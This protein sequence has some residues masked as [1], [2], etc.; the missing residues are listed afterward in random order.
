M[1]NQDTQKVEPEVKL[2]EEELLKAL[3]KL[4][5]V[6]VKPKEPESQ[7]QKIELDTNAL[8]TMQSLMSEKLQKGMTDNSNLT[9]IVTLM[10]AHVDKTIG[11]LTK[12]I[13][14]ALVRDEAV[15]RLL[16]KYDVT[17]EQM[18]KSLGTA[19][20]TPVPNT[21]PAAVQSDVLEKSTASAT[22][23]PEVMKKSVLSGLQSLIREHKAT[24]HE[25]QM[26]TEALIKF[27][28]TNQIS[29]SDLAA[30]KKAAGI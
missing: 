27:E 26:Y 9:E 24:S 21:A 18:S 7:V 16:K 4:E 6:E 5:G 25:G 11:I 14:A 22:P 19:M 8:D 29:N 17:M 23:T 1:D 3:T 12:S 30:A 2:T 28:S 13:N 10:G 15:L 20:S